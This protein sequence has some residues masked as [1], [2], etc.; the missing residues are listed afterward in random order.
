MI[1]P[2]SY[3]ALTVPSRARQD[4]RHRVLE[5][6][7]AELARLEG[8]AQSEVAGVVPLGLP[9]LDGALPGGGLARGCLHEICGAPDQAAAAGFAAALLGRLATEA[10]VVWIGPRHDLFAPGLAE[11]GLAPENL[12]VVRAREREARLWALEEVL[13]S[14]GVGA[15]LAEI[16]RLGLTESRRLQLAAESAGVTG[17]LLRAPGALATPCA[18]VTRWRIGPL[19]GAG[20]GANLGAPR[21]QVELVRA[22]GGRPGSRAVEWRKGGW[23]EIPGAFALAAEP[24]DRPADPARTA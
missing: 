9:G 4:N 16:G 18:A 3:A 17:F 2:C 10:P 22:R 23:H 24:S 8:T 19:G 12:I 11:I 14:S 15:G 13:R 5:R 21:W 20:P 6:L 7:R 1:E